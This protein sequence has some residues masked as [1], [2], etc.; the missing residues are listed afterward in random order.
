MHPCSISDIFSH[1]HEHKI[2][3]G[4]AQLDNSSIAQLHSTFHCQ[5][6][7]LAGYIF[8]T[9]Q[10]SLIKDL[11]NDNRTFLIER[12]V[13]LSTTDYAWGIDRIDQRNLP[14][15]GIYSFQNSR[16]GAGTTVFVI[17]SGINVHHDEFQG[18]AVWGINT[19]DNVDDDLNGHGTH[20]AGIVGGA[21]VGVAK[22][23]SI[24]AI[25]CVDSDGYGMTSDVLLGLAF[26]L[27]QTHLSNKIVTM[28][29]ISNGVNAILDHVAKLLIGQG[30]PIVVS[31]G[32]SA[33]NVCQQSLTDINQVL[34]VAA[35]DK[36]D[37]FASFSNYGPCIN[38][39]A[40]GV[41]IFSSYIGGNGFYKFLS[42]TSM[43]AP[44]VT[45]VVARLWSNNLTVDSNNIIKNLLDLS[46]T[47][48][49]QGVPAGTPNR[50]LY[51]Q[52]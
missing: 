41:N 31:A 50:N 52:Q 48:I 45:G 12:D 25:K 8:N 10:M 16:N 34:K 19:V 29:L 4:H 36:T 42:G 21:T 40:P 20:V 38:L 30:V 23:V 13:K 46:T 33:Q 14:L 6:H 11:N 17:D 39:I 28:S 5:Q 1:L 49:I 2:Y 27:Q 37:T 32:N 43:A 7:N 22:D 47:N 26:V 15:D 9:E 24:V 3:C 18:R 35:A 51:I 44:F